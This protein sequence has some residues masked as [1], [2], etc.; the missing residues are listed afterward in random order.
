MKYLLGL[1]LLFMV[2]CASNEVKSTTN[3]FYFGCMNG[4]VSR[5]VLGGREVT[6]EDLRF[7]HVICKKLEARYD[8]VLRRAFEPPPPKRPP[9]EFHDRGRSI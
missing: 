3:D 5:H 4:A 2:G 9:H 6:G 7:F 8:E 1:S